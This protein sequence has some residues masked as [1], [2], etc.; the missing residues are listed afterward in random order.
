MT[1]KYTSKE[2]NKFNPRDL[3]D[4]RA[5]S[6]Y[7]TK[8]FIDPETRLTKLRNETDITDFEHPKN[9][10]MKYL[11][12]R[13]LLVNSYIERRLNWNE[14]APH[15]ILKLQPESNKDLSIITRMLLTLGRSNIDTIEKL[16]ELIDNS[17]IEEIRGI[18][19]K[20]VDRL[21]KAFGTRYTN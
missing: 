13:N 2:R 8:T 9:Q 11:E 21:K 16:L 7:D 10:A 18:G 17:E 15:L 4:L 19:K 6:V 20:T 1:E 3:A 12:D 14:L 5:V